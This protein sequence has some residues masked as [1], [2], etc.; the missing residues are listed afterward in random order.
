[1]HTKYK[2]FLA[3][4]VLSISLGI[5]LSIGQ[6]MTYYT[7]PTSGTIG[8]N[9]QII[10]DNYV[11]DKSEMRGIFFHFTSL[12]AS[13]D[14]NLILQTLSDYNINTLVIEVVMPKYIAYTSNVISASAG[15]DFKNVLQLAHSL[16]IE[17][18]FAMDVLYQTPKQEWGCVDSKDSFIDWL[19]PNKPAVRAY[20]KAIVEEMLTKYPDLDGFMFDYIRWE[21]QGI[22]PDMDYSPESKAEL[23]KWLGETIANFPGDFAPGGS[24]YNTFLEWRIE[25][26]TQLLVDMRGW[27]KAIKPDLKI[28]AAPWTI[29]KTGPG[30]EWAERRKLIG[31]D[32]TDWVMKDYLD[33]VAPMAYF[34]PSELEVYFRSSVKASIDLGAGGPEGKVPVVVF[35]ANQFPVVKTPAEFKAEIDIVRAEGADGWIIW[36]YGGPGVGGVDIRDHLNSLNL[37]QVFSMRDIKVFLDQQKKSA[38]ATWSTNIPTTGRVEYSS[39]PLFNVTW[40]YDSG[41]NFNYLDIDHVQGTIVEDLQLSLDHSVTLSNLTPNTTYYFR[42]QSQSS[43]IVTSK[44]YKF[45]ING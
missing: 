4:A 26:I 15:L 29:L 9:S 37:P 5:S 43:G 32:W 23:E 41:W 11:V 42:V 14:W 20:L 6:Y 35:V 39:S 45:S 8:Q 18:Y 34:Y 10:F 22:T 44:V 36:K 21:W 13:N 1:M 24:R 17:V 3:I 30:Y 38:T 25:V 40:R 19:N 27:M 31:Q 28:S 7:I 33:W 2:E 12:S 16:G